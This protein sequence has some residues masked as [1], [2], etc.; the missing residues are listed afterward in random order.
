MKRIT[1]FVWLFLLLLAS[2]QAQR[3]RPAAPG[4][5]VWKPA[6]TAQAAAL[7][8]IQ[9]QVA[10]L[11]A[12][13]TAM[14]A[15]SAAEGEGAEGL[16]EGVPVVT[17]TPSPT[18]TPVGTVEAGV[19]HA[20]KVTGQSGAHLTFRNVR[21]VEQAGGFRPS[22]GYRWLAVDVAI[23]NPPNNAA[24]DYAP[25]WFAVL[26]DGGAEQVMP[27][28]IVGAPLMSL[29]TIPP[30]G[31]T[32][33]TLVFRIPADFADQTTYTLQIQDAPLTMRPPVTVR[34]EVVESG[35]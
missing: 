26:L 19:S 8:A 28:P 2:C 9:T 20:V 18:P 29:V 22:P 34:L 32:S 27:I 11:Q 3:P 13:L 24:V 6:A 10:H 7:Q 14:P 35:Q 23:D 16:D 12:A 5:P 4:T 30:G 17:N 25:I 21:W 15:A 33:G 1:F 31:R